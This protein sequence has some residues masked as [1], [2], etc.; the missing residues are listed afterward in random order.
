MYYLSCQQIEIINNA[1]SAKKKACFL[2]IWKIA[3]LLV[4]ESDFFF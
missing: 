3:L 2:N 4:K 1:R